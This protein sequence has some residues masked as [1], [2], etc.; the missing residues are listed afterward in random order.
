MKI[1]EV[2]GGYGSSNT[3]SQ[4]KVTKVTG[5]KATLVDPSKPGI[6]TTID[7]DKVEIDTDTDGKN[8]T[9]KPSEKSKKIKS[10]PLKPNSKVTIQTNANT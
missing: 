2:T 9:I 1:F 3:G 5:K 10:N 8:T 6:E 4:M 7:T